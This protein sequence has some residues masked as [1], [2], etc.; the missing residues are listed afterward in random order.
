MPTE[1]DHQST[2]QTPVPNS[3]QKLKSWHEDSEV[4]RKSSD[5]LEGRHWRGRSALEPVYAK[6]DTKV[7]TILG[8]FGGYGPSAWKDESLIKECMMNC[9]QQSREA[10]SC[11]GP[12]VKLGTWGI[13]ANAGMQP[14]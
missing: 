10:V 2:V 6:A 14:L 7:L 3:S 8:R 9:S 11:F 5:V 12:E 13:S 4:V 1:L